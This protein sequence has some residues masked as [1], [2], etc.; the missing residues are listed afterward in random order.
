MK[1][2]DGSERFEP[3]LKQLI[4]Y[5]FEK[6]LSFYKN[7]ISGIVEIVLVY[8]AIYRVEKLG[9]DFALVLKCDRMA[10]KWV[11]SDLFAVTPQQDNL[12]RRGRLLYGRPEET[13]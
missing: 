6:W 5:P 10:D 13:T 2:G 3:F 11:A 8:I 12:F 4:E 1:T 7:T 9:K